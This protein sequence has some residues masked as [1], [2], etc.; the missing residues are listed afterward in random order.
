MSWLSLIPLKYRVLAGA[1][2]A[3][4]LLVGAA[5]LGWLAQGWR[6]GERMAEQGR[7]LE[8]Q[9]AVRDKL[10][11]DTLA[12][13]QSAAAGEARRANEKRLTL[14]Q[15]LQAASQN[16]HR[17]LTDAEKTAARLRDRL[18]TA[19]L[20]L[21][22]LVASPGASDAGGGAVSSTAS[23]GRLV[24]GA[25][26]ADIDAGSAQRIV[27]I[28]ERGDRAIIA[29]GMCQAYARTISLSP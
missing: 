23:A 7:E 20:R 9:I 1:S 27:G 14:E 4:T 6:L 24:D 17:R 18:A 26:R 5:G 13:A 22:V 16:Q 8:Q 10:H 12:M 2:L 21:S 19:E 28:V 25:R 29:L 15:Q 11:A 3:V